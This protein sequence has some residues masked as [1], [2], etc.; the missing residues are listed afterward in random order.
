MVSACSLLSQRCAGAPGRARVWHSLQ[1]RA[2]G[3]CNVE[4]EAVG[5][6]GRV[7]MATTPQ[8]PGSTGS[9]TRSPHFDW[10]C[11]NCVPPPLRPPA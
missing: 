7:R 1:L 4:T 3:C 8:E 10:G 9:V 6:R 2:R 11:F 5:P